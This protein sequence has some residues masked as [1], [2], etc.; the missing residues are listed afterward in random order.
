M[1][2]HNLLL[3]T[4][5]LAL[6]AFSF[7]PVL[8]M[9]EDG[10]EFN[11]DETPSSTF[12]ERL[13]AWS[14]KLSAMGEFIN[15]LAATES[16][17]EVIRKFFDNETVDSLVSKIPGN[18][19]IKS[20]ARSIANNEVIST[21]FVENITARLEELRPIV[22]SHPG[23]SRLVNIMTRTTGLLEDGIMQLDKTLET[24]DEATTEAERELNLNKIS[25]IL[26][27]LEKATNSL[28]A[29]VG[30]ISAVPG[31]HQAVTVPLLAP[32]TVAKTALRIAN[33]VVKTAPSAV[34]SVLGL[35]SIGL[36]AVQSVVSK[37]TEVL[38]HLV[39]EQS[40]ETVE[41]QV[42]PL[43]EAEPALALKPSPAEEE[44]PPNPPCPRVIVISEPFPPSIGPE[45]PPPDPPIIVR[46]SGA[47]NPLTP[48]VP[49]TSTV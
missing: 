6:H 16:A 25:T 28:I 31:P 27:S 20:T 46:T 34:R 1:K 21:E 4:V 44:E 14:N 45:P 35:L 36:S 3:A 37:T 49:V 5:C 30:I 13:E 32:L 10:T 8:A 19:T 43:V 26:T 15:K 7:N 9:E 48:T 18:E 17:G 39:E 29:V 2:K 22:S 41:V 11:F 12:P 33:V 38:S 24:L 47:S 42:G 40:A 23:L